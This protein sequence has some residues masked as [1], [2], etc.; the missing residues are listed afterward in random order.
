MVAGVSFNKRIGFSILKLPVVNSIASWVYFGLRRLG[1]PF[2][3]FVFPDKGLLRVRSLPDREFVM[4]NNGKDTIASRLKRDGLDGFEPEL[5]PVLMKLV[6]EAQVFLD[7]GANTGLYSL[8]AASANPSCEVHAFEPVPDIRGS[9][10][11]NLRRN[12]FPQVRAWS[13][14]LSSCTRMGE[15]LIPEEIRYSTGGTELDDSSTKY[16]RIPVQFLKLDEFV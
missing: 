9:F 5:R 2:G 11:E 7:I 8:F 10:E 16:N 4:W 3:D 12:N 6:P 1:I 14:A 15:F 13:E